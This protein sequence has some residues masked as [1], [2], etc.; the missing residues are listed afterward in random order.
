MITFDGRKRVMWSINVSRKRVAYAI[1]QR[2]PGVEVRK[3]MHRGEIIDVK[4]SAL[5]D[6]KRAL[7]IA[8]ASR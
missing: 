4:G 7:D 5:A 1:V 8:E 6:V 3:L 2:W